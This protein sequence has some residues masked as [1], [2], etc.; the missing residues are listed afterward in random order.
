[1]PLRN[2]CEIVEPVGG[3]VAPRNILLISLAVDVSLC[4]CSVH[5]LGVRFY[6]ILFLFRLVFWL[7]L[8]KIIL[9]VGR[10]RRLLRGRM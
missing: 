6:F 7:F 10:F 9:Y 3:G 5:P 1:M 2:F 8:G 4:V